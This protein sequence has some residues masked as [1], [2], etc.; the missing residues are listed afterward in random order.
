MSRELPSTRGPTSLPTRLACSTPTGSRPRT[1]SE[2]RRAGPSR[3]RP[4]PP[5]PRASARLSSAA[6][7]VPALPRPG[8]G[9][10]PAPTERFERFL[11]TAE[12][13]WSDRDSVV[14]YVVGYA[15]MLAGGGRRL[16]AGRAP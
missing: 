10:L 7:L 13:D 5:L 2:S 14:D 6:R 1:W 8:G 3:R 4:P 12:V 9:A 15:E 16:R 11:A